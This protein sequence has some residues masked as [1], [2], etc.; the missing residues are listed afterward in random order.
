MNPLSDRTSFNLWTGTPPGAL[1][2]DDK[3]TPTLT[4]FFPKSENVNG[5]AMV[6]LPGGGYNHLAPHEGVGYAEWLAD[7]GFFC[8]VLKYRLSAAGYRHPVMLADAAKAMRVARRLAATL[9]IRPDKIGMIGSSA[10][11]HLTA[12][13]GHLHHLG[14]TEP[15]EIAAP[16]EG[17]PD[18][19]VLCYPVV[20]F[21]KPFAH[22]GSKTAILGPSPSQDLVDQ[23]SAEKS[24]TS[25]YP[26]TFVWHTVADPGVPVENSLLLAQSLR[27]AGVPFEL[28]LYEKGGH[29]LG[30]ANGHPWTIECLR[31]LKER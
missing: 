9:G 27:K 17:R 2:T 28:H 10:G 15:G 7:N 29:G 13:T 31:W 22:E 21:N 8:F 12:T 6:I 23:L 25:A 20:T 4:P 16:N 18:F 19:L 26:P 14:L 30:L 11:A 1:G 3:D 24:V 5:K